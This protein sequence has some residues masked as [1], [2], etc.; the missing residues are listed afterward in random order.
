MALDDFNKAIFLS[1]EMKQ[2]YN[3]RGWTLYKL[4]RPQEAQYDFKQA[5]EIDENYASPY[6]SMGLIDYIAEKFESALTYLKK[7]NQLNPKDEKALEFL[8]KSQD[9][10]DEKNKS[11]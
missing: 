5:I 7:A 1:P 6:V 4:G 10:L 8:K 9:K 3:S 2:A 11:I